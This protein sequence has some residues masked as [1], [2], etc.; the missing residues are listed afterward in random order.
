[1][2]TTYTALPRADGAAEVIRRDRFNVSDV[3]A[4]C[5][6]FWLAEEVCAALQAAADAGDPLASTTGRLAEARRELEEVEREL[7]DRES[8]V[9]EAEDRLAE[10]GKAAAMFAVPTPKGGDAR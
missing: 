4:V 2:P 1:M 8:D 6:T 5:P 7:G 9:W 10:L 3:V